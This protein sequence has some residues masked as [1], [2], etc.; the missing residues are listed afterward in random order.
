MD[1][2]YIIN[3]SIDMN[4]KVYSDFHQAKEYFLY[5]IRLEALDIYDG[6]IPS[7]I[8]DNFDQLKD[9]IIDSL[10]E[11]YGEITY[12]VSEREFTLYEREVKHPQ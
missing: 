5:L 12:G 10:L 3:D 8:L 6:E 9:Y 11:R 1:K 2:I 7:S 4:P